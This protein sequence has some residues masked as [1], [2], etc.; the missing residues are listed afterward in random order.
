[1]PQR[2]TFSEV[3]NSTI[4]RDIGLCAEQRSEV[5]AQVNI[6]IEELIAD[7][8]A[9][10]E[11]WWGGYVHVVFQVPVVACNATL[12]TPRE[13]AR[14]DVLDICQR[15]RFIRNGFYEYL[16]FGRGKQPRGCNSACVQ[17]QQAFDRDLVPLLSPFP[18]TGPQTIRFFPSNNADIGKR[19]QIQGPDQN[20]KTVYSVDPITGEAIIGEVV[21]LVAPFATAAFQYQNITGLAKDYTLGPVT[22]FAVDA[23]GHSTQI[24]AMEPNE[25]TASYRQ[26]FLNGL[27]AACCNTPQGVVQ[28]DAQCK[29]DFIPVINDSDP[30]LIQSIPAIRRK[31]MALRW[32]TIDSAAAS[33]KESE[34][35][36]AALRILNGQI[37]HYEGKT[38]TAISMPI[39]GSDRARLN[40]V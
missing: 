8:L 19:I 23:S 6:A 37:D 32:S 16:K 14:I 35:N 1:M 17:T 24:S 18:S 27:P 5:A 28:V 7:P 39:F 22:V 38:R 29:L 9:P 10:E 13:I 36:A 2:P 30:L 3:L 25:T 34:N 15:P 26:Y 40:P 4:P 12:I 21:T 33:K 20:G 31:C 11:G